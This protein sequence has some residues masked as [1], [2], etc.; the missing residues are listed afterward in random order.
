MDKNTAGQKI[1]VQMID[2]TTGAAFTGT[3]TVYITGDAGTQAIGTV[4]S[5]VCTHEGNGYH[6]YAPSADETNFDLIAFTFTGTGAVP[7]TIQV[8]TE[9]EDC[10]SPAEVREIVEEELEQWS[11]AGAGGSTPTGDDVTDAML[12]DAETGVE[13]SRNDQGEVQLMKADDRIKLHKYAAANGSAD[14]PNRGARFNRIIP[15]D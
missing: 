8:E 9:D 13:R 7:Q 3:V 15:A 12:S 14:A 1:G 2:A 10:A 11:D 4:G 5:G 6:T